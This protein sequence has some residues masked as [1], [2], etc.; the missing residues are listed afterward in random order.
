MTNFL[1]AAALLS[2]FI[3][4]GVKAEGYTVTQATQQPK[5][6]TF[7]YSRPE[8]IKVNGKL[9]TRTVYHATNGKNYV[10]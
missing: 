5:N 7:M 6:V 2:M 4:N 10:Q 8:T 9:Y 1:I 3:M